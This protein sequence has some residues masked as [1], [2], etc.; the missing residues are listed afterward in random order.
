M[1]VIGGRTNQSARLS[2]YKFMT[3]NQANGINSNLFRDSDTNAGL[4]EIICMFMED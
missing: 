1:I 2:R 4:Q 3:L